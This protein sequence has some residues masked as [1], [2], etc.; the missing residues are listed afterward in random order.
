MKRIHFRNIGFPKTGTTWLWYQLI[1]HPEVDAK[2]NLIFKE[3]LGRNLEEYKKPYEKYNV[4]MNLHTHTF[5]IDFPLNHYCLPE[6]VSEYTTH[7]TFR[8][9][10]PYELLNSYYNYIKNTNPNATFTAKDYLTVDSGSVKMFCDVKKIFDNWNKCKANFKYMFYDDLVNDPKKHM[11]EICE[12]LGI[13]KFYDP[14]IKVKFKTD[15]KEQ[16]IFD[17]KKL[18]KYINDNICVIEDTL[19]RDLSHWKK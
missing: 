6:L 13:N 17:D 1:S 7:V 19:K 4:S 9:R 5:N 11:Y 10:N 16:L 14:K 2:I 8:F 3:S 12:F 18:I 15:I